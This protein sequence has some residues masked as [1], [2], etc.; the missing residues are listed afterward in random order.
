MGKLEISEAAMLKPDQ[1]EGLRPRLALAYQSWQSGHD[2]RA[3]L[4][5]KT[6]YRYRRELMEF[7]V[8][9]AVKRPGSPE[10]NV[11]PLRVVLH[12]YPSG[13]PEWAKGTPLYFDPSERK[14][15]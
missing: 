15:A 9:I 8:D 2:L 1:L 6:F 12:A 11:I 14:A 4:P 3:L 10:S 13:V 7:G 5:R